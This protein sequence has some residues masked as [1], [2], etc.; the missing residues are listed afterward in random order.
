MKKYKLFITITLAIIILISFIP[1]AIKAEEIVDFEEKL[2][3]IT[4]QEKSIIEQLFIG[5]QEIE[6]LERDYLAIN[7]EIEILKI[8]VSD[9]EINI[10]KKKISIIAI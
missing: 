6:G 1:S 5:L 10:Q 4:D 3:T 2:S 9:L 8:D 7:E